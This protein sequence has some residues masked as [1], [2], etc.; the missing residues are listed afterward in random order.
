[1]LLGIGLLKILPFFDSVVPSNYA[2]LVSVG[3]IAAALFAGVSFIGKRESTW[4][5]IFDA[6][7]S[8]GTFAVAATLAAIVPTDYE[9]ISVSALFVAAALT[10]RNRTGLT[11]SWFA[12]A[13][14]IFTLAQLGEVRAEA[15]S[16]SLNLSALAVVALSAWY[17][18]KTRKEGRF[19]FTFAL[20]AALFITSDYVRVFSENVF[21]VT[22]YLAFVAAGLLFAGIS[23]DVPKFRTAGLY[24][25][26]Y[27]L[28]KI[29]FYDLWAGVDD[30]S[31]RVLALMV[32]G[33]LMIALS[34]LYGRSVKRGWSEEFSWRN[35]SDISAALDDAGEG[36]IKMATK[37]STSEDNPFTGSVAE[38]LG[39]ID[40]SQVLA[41]RFVDAS[42]TSFVLRR[43][44]IF[45]IAVRISETFGKTEFRPGEL[46]A[47]FDKAVPYVK[48]SLAKKDLDAVLAKLS[49]WIASGGSFEIQKK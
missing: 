19:A 22:I 11:G 40:V 2:S 35:F 36:K 15:L 32:T 48:S 3:L 9:A 43:A 24:V 38:E 18:S 10:Y 14:A 5:G 44:G 17:V 30:L 25:G 16:A 1:M 46:S 20:V 7:H 34:Q 6:L 39:K 4:S 13:T 12:V 28:V 31:V 37:I 26:S 21:A 23:A 27:M 41:V 42:G 29:L 33:G 8:I 47:V 45:R 49:A